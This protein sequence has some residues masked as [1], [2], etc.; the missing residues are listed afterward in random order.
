MD[1]NILMTR[2]FHL[3]TM[4]WIGAMQPFDPPHASSL[5]NPEEKK[6]SGFDQTE[7][8]LCV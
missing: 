1:I 5:V 4:H 7:K 2:N 6:E 3:D 8:V